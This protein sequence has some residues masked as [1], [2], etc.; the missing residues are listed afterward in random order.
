MF[1]K[2][3]FLLPDDKLVQMRIPSPLRLKLLKVEKTGTS[4]FE[5]EA[6]PLE[7]QTMETITV[8]NDPVCILHEEK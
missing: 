4:Q 3:C 5:I 6:K 1:F 8:A 7:G 2:N